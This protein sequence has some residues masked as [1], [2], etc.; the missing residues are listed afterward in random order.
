MAE[1][2]ALL[3]DTNEPLLLSEL[4][5]V[6]TAYVLSSVY[7]MQRADITDALMDLVQRH[8]FQSLSLPKP[9]LLEALR[10]CRDSKRY[11]FTDAF[12]WAQARMLGVAIYSFDG[13]FPSEGIE[14]LEI[15]L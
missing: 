9:L 2:A 3:V 6:E 7:G 11:S 12:L 5:L 8:N 1:Q 14:I 13:R 15:P 4:V 10:L